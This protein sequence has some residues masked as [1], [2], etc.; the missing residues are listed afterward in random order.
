MHI[1]KIPIGFPLSFFV[2]AASLSSELLRRCSESPP[3]AVFDGGQKRNQCRRRK[4]RGCGKAEA[5]L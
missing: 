5:D 1:P 4:R 3:K 2:S